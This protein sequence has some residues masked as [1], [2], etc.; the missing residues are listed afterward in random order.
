[1]RRGLRPAPVEAAAESV[2]PKFECQRLPFEAD[3]EGAEE[4][5][6]GQNRRRMRG[7]AQPRT[8]INTKHTEKTKRKV[9][10]EPEPQLAL[11]LSMTIA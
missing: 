9:S 3:A 2:K 5:M 8:E 10:N 6:P 7:T 11:L 4:G 1:M